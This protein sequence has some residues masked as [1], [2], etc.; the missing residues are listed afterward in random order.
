MKKL[1]IVA[2]AASLATPVLAAPLGHPGIPAT[3]VHDKTHAEG[4]YQ[5]VI[6]RSQPAAVKEEPKEEQKAVVAANDCAPLWGGATKDQKDQ[7]QA[8]NGSDKDRAG[9]VVPLP[10]T[11][12]GMGLATP[13]YGQLT[14]GEAVGIGAAVVAIGAAIGNHG[15]GGGHHSSGTSGTTGTTK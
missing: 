1:L 9:A 10:P 5:D 12:S 2:M 15:G 3:E 7:A 13:L 4:F 6:T 14:V 8:A 11:C